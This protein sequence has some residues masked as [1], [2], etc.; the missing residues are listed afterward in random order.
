M[1]RSPWA[2][3]RPPGSAEPAVELIDDDGQTLWASPTSGPPLNL[4]HLPA[5]AEAILVL[6]PAELVASVEGAKML[7][8]IGPASA[9]AAEEIQADHPLP[10]G[11]DR[12]APDR[13]LSGR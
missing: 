1:N 12:A 3:A 4:G 6:R 2:C 5:G 11:R 13:I 8:A 7:E 10:M 9:T